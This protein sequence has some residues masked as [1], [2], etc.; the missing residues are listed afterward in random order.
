MEDGGRMTSEPRD[1]EGAPASAAPQHPWYVQPT[2]DASP[3]EPGQT[4]DDTASSA[5]GLREVA[6]K[7]EEI[8]RL[9]SEQQALQGRLE[10]GG[11]RSPEE[12][13][14]E[15]LMAAHRA[16]EAV[17]EGARHEAAQVVAEARREAAPILGDAYRVLDETSA[18]HREAQLA[19]ERARLQAEALLE[20]AQAEHV[21]LIASSVSAAEQ[22]RAEL[23]SE[24]TRLSKAINDLRAEWVK[25]ANDAL[26]RL[27][28][29]TLA[30]RPSAETKALSGT[31]PHAEGAAAAE[32]LDAD[33][34]LD[35]QSRLPDGVSPTFP[36]SSS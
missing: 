22:R 2:G 1:L 18:L 36:P 16:A 30:A 26:A 8:A 32:G 33:V 17:L 11:R 6:A 5:D 28:K 15:A 23:D 25:R 13:V 12:L 21:R 7:Q 4:R 24:N 14:G 34:A 27:D 29:I 3:Q 20:A 35:L 9:R 31:P 19:V 10:R